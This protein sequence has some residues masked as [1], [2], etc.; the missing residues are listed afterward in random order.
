[1][2]ASCLFRDQK[3]PPLFCQ[4]LGLSAA[5]SE[6]EAYSKK[7]GFPAHASD[8]FLSLDVH[9]RKPRGADAVGDVVSLELLPK[10]TTTSLQELRG[11][12]L[13]NGDSAVVAESAPRL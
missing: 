4:S 9:V 11:Q 7:K 13:L 12:F 1:M 8:V 3:L 2:R 5:D 6:G 10:A